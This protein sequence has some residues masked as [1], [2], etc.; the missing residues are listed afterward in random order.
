[1][2]NPWLELKRMPPYVVSNDREQVA[3]FNRSASDDVKLRVD[4]L[5]EPYIGD[6]NAPV[7]LLAASP[8]WHPEDREALPRSARQH[9]SARSGDRDGRVYPATTALRGGR[10]GLRVPNLIGYRD[11]PSSG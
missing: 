10:S 1:M 6:V 7:V 8:G 9:V 11:H 5:P 4:L 3:A 2:S